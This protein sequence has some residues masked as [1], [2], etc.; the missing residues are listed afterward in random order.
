MRVRDVHGC[1]LE[2][3]TGKGDDEVECHQHDTFHVVALAVLDEQ[4]DKEHADK[5]GHSLKVVEEER[6]LMARTT[7]FR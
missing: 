2:R 1:E 5:E 4:I 7:I 6:E 3:R